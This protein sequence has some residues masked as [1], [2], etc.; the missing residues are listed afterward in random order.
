MYIF[1]GSAIL[2]FVVEA[3]SE[4][5]ALELVDCLDLSHYQLNKVDIED[6]EKINPEERL[7]DDINTERMLD[8]IDRRR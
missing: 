4:E 1:S 8:E 2:N 5:E 3:E 6:C 7:A